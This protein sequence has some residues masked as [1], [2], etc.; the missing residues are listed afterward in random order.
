MK[1]VSL[2]IIATLLLSFNASDIS[3]SPFDSSQMASVRVGS[4]APE[5]SFKDPEGN[6]RNLSDLRGK[7]VMLDFWASWCGPCRQENPSVVKTYHQF[8]DANFKSGK[9]FEI[10]SV[11]LDQ[12]KD[13]WIKAIEQD[14]LGWDNHVSDLRGWSSRGAAIYGINSIPRTF[15]IDG[16][17]KIIGMNLR[18]QQIANALKAL[19]K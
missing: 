19:Q 11:S 18:G 6:M 12:S 8:K 7:I 16:K 13:R 14:K 17:G 2:W 15:L 9:G 4:M 10:F 3:H 5:L 1:Q